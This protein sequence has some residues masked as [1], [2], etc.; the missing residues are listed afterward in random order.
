MFTIFPAWLK[1]SVSPFYGPGVRRAVSF[2]VICPEDEKH[3]YT[4]VDLEKDFIGKRRKVEN[5]LKIDTAGGP[6]AKLQGDNDLRGIS[7]A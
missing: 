3:K 7:D 5:V 2:N 4:V 1:H 6:D